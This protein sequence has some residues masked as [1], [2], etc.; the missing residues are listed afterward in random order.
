VTEWFAALEI[1]QR[2]RDGGY[3]ALFAGGCVRDRL[4]QRE[5]KDYDIAT[6]AT[7]AQVLSLFPKGNEVG[8]H[9]GVILVRH[10]GH[11][12]EIATFRTDGSYSDGRRP[13]QVVFATAEEDAQRRDFTINGLL[14][15]PVSGEIID[16]V[17]GRADLE[18]GLLR[19]IGDASKRFQEDSLRLMRAL[20]FATGLGFAIEEK[21]WTAIVQQA[22]LLARI[23]PERIREELNRMLIHP[24][25]AQAFQLLADSGLFTQFWPEVM[26]LI[27]CEQPPEWHP[28]GDVFVHTK[29]MLEMLEPEAPLELVLAVLLHDIAKPPTRTVDADAGGRIRFNGHDALGAE[30]AADMLR[31]LRYSNDTIDAVVP[32]VAR[33]MQFM[34]VQQMRTAKLKRFM[35]TPTFEH[36]LE[37]HRVDCGSSNGFTDNLDY[38]IAKR[39][40]FSREPLIPEPLMTGRDLINAGF[41]PG[42]LFREILDAIQIEQLEGR[43]HTR[44]EAFAYFQQHWPAQGE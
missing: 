21:T 3:Q 33:H 41:Q 9:F 17:G 44:E 2:L 22:P 14:E 29:I 20:R 38:L 11:M 4:L 6:N 1:A 34:N 12:I 23:A 30:M 35:A 8:A 10:Q 32:M 28:E 31:R 16:Y 15:D 42:P 13:D 18:A 40:E 19:A 26:D 39:E 24:S 37:L 43:L 36:E 25:R 27:G 7:P 5:P